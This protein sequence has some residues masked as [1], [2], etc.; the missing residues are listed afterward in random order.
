MKKWLIFDTETTDLVKPEAAA[1]EVQPKIIEIGLIEI[2][3]PGGG[4]L[5]FVAQEASWLINPGCK[6][7][8][9]ITKITGL[10]N[11]D[12]LGKPSF[13]LVLPEVTQWFLGTTGLICHNLPFDLMML[14]NELRRCG[15]EQAFPYP[16][17]Q[18]CTVLNYMDLMGRRLKLT[19]LYNHVMKK[20][21]VQTHRALDD[22]RAL[23][24]IVL[25]EGFLQD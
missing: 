5:P 16:P 10:T 3:C 9:E 19:E 23:A 18:I 12:L 15:K 1:L 4:E 21:L 8:A 22:C 17:E 6:I 25:A 7:T 2:Q 11:D 24:E 13:P 14:V 20:E